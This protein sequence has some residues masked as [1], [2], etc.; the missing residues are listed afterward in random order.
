MNRITASMKNK[1]AELQQQCGIKDIQPCIALFQ[2]YPKSNVSEWSIRIA[3]SN[4]PDMA[5]AD[6]LTGGKYGLY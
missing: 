4:N 5:L 2:I 3:G 1:A 6:I